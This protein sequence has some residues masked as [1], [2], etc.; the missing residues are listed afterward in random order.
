M[1]IVFMGTPEF[2]VPTLN[3]LSESQ[4]EIVSVVTAPDKKTGR[5]LKMTSSPVK[6]RALKLD[7]PVL[8]PEL[9]DD[10]AF[11]DD[12]SS[13]MPDCIVVV[14]F[15]IL[16]LKVF[17]I[18]P[19]GTINLH[20]SLLPLYRGAA[21]I[22]WAIIRGEKETGITTFLIDKNVDTGQILLQKTYPIGPEETAGELAQKLSVGGAE[23]I[24][25]TLHGIEQG[26]LT[27]IGQEQGN[28]PK[29]PKLGK[30]TSILDWSKSSHDVHN[31]VRGLSPVPGAISMLK[32]KRIKILRTRLCDTGTFEKASPG[33]IL[34]ANAREG[35]IVSCGSGTV[36]IMELMRE[37][38]NAMSAVSFL[39]GSRGLENEEF[40]S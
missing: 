8:Q 32:N 25:S 34:R 26:N 7:I 15:R 12:L 27:P 13:C 35:F 29:A 28:F 2:A 5:G 31:L 22:N 16:P 10:N 20:A 39:V 17:K 19:R 6:L 30:E 3:A 33:R 38:K 1:R 18:P 23:L 36:E 4:H 21:P 40:C 24:I 37:G 14:A 9:L 11:V